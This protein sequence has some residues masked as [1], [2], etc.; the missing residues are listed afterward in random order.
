MASKIKALPYKEHDACRKN[1][2][3]VLIIEANGSRYPIE[4]CGKI[5]FYLAR[6]RQIY[7]W[8]TRVVGEYNDNN[9]RLLLAELEEEDARHRDTDNGQ[10]DRTAETDINAKDGSPQ[11]H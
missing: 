10:A 3:L 1:H 4:S 11:D 7:G 5:N 6:M 8:K 2:M 9:L